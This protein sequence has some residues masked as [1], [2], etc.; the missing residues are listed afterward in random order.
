MSV[1]IEN[2]GLALPEGS[3]T[4]ADF[5]RWAQE[6]SRFDDRSRRLIPGLF[7]RSGVAKRHSVLLKDED[8]SQT[9]FTPAT[10]DADRGPSTAARMR[11]YQREA[12][13]LALRAARAALDESRDVTHLVTVS[14]TGFGAPG[15]DVALV[16]ALELGPTVERTHIGF[17]GCH[18]ALNGLRVA[19]MILEADPRARVLLCALELCSLHYDYGD[20]PDRIVANGL[21]SDGAAAMVLVA[22]EQE[23]PWRLA[24]SGSCLLADSESAMAW[25]IGDH[26]FEMRLSPEIPAR[27]G[28]GLRPWM[29]AWLAGRGL[30]IERIG[31]WAVHP[32][33]P[34]ILTATETALG[35]REDATADSR[36]VLAEC[37]NMSSPTVLFI[38][39]RMRRRDAPRPCVALAFGPG[40]TAEAALFL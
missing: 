18:G 19:R 31:S 33:G 17:M 36:S 28:E 25:G 15:F 27:I 1:H 14:C 4:Q 7:R 12:A 2:I 24:A 11:C 13:P 32:G 21:F 30:C 38:L 8:S 5:A 29:V 26:G 16:K 20:D 37:G 6:I 10:H 34:R 35:L 3:I 40:L 23:R 39:D 22:G 9:F